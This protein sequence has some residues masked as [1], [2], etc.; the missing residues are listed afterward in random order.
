MVANDEIKRITAEVTRGKSDPEAKAKA[1]FYYVQEKT[2]YVAKEL[3]IGAIQPRPASLTCE[4]R[5]GDCH[6]AHER[7]SGDSV[8]IGWARRCRGDGQRITDRMQYA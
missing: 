8:A 5:Y 6:A 1:I 2:R 4:N 7:T 3:G